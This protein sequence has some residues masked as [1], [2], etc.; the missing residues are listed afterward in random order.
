MAVYERAGKDVE[1]VIAKV[2]KQFHKDLVDLGVRISALMATPNKNARG[3]SKGPAVKHG[4]YPCLA[5][6]KITKLNERVLGLADAIITIDAE[7]WEALPEGERKALI[8][9]ELEHL[10]PVHSK[11][12]GFKTDDHGR[13][14]LKGRLHD[15]QLGGFESV[16]RRHAD[17]AAEVRGLLDTL[18]RP[19]L[20]QLNLFHPLKEAG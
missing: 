17:R 3:E 20:V 10:E 15:W 1:E 8:D 4:G 2:L 9:H 11:K 12:A 18:R 16:A 13:P 6:I 19:T 14:L 5:T 7:A